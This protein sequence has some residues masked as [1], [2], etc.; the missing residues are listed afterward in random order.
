MTFFCGADA[1]S[2]LE[3][4]AF[5]AARHYTLW[6]AQTALARGFKARAKYVPQVESA[7]A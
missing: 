3:E 6:L 4:E 2:A 5:G 7:M 1:L